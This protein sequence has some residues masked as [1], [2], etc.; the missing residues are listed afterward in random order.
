[1]ATIPERFSIEELIEE[2]V[3]PSKIIKP[4]MTG[5]KVIKKTIFPLILLSNTPK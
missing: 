4:S 3:Y 1:M 5:W 2:I